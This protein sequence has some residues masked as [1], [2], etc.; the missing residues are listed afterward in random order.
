MSTPEQQADDK[1]KDRSPSFPFISLRD[2]VE[3]AKVLQKEEGRNSASY[4][5]TVAHWKYGA[6]SSG[7]KRMVAALRAYGLLDV[8]Q[9]GRYKLTPAA[10]Q[11]VLDTPERAQALRDAALR[12]TWF[13]KMWERH[14]VDLPSD[15]NLKNTLYL[16]DG[17]TEDAADDFIKAYRDTI[18]F[19]GLNKDVKLS[20][21]PEDKLKIGV[22]DY[23]Q[24][25]SNGELKFEKPRKVIGF[26]EDGWAKVEG[27]DSGIPV[28]QLT[29]EK[30]PEE[31]EPGKI[32]EAVGT[33]RPRP[34]MNTYVCTLDNGNARIEW[35]KSITQE[36]LELVNIWLE[37]MKKKIQRSVGQE[38]TLHG[39]MGPKDEGE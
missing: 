7:G 22:G 9:Q 18:E 33:T 2:A 32:V 14:G 31:S 6:K 19:A 35:P 1:K 38:G 15:K 11:I 8:D 29:K 25:E 16:M 39:A 30:P 34:G 5:V 23:V 26:Y 27:T 28:A 4:A 36:D 3:K 21:P 20:S 10:L 13:Q 24:W 17:F 12:P 37:T